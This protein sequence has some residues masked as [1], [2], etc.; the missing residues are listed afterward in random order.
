MKR[1]GMRRVN[2]KRLALLL[3]CVAAAVFAAC[4]RAVDEPADGHP[5]VRVAALHG[6][7]ALGLL[8]LMDTHDRG[9]AVL[10]YT[11]EILGAPMEV[12]P[13][14]VRGDVDIAVVPGNLAAV[15]YNQMD[16]AIQ[17]LAVVT[18][19]VLH[20]VDATDEV[21]SVEDLRGRT[22]FATGE[23]ATP[24]F[25]L[26]YV[27]VQNGLIPGADVFIEFRSQPPEIA[28]A[29]ELGHAEVALLPEPFVSNITA[30]FDHLRVALDWTEEWNRAQSNYGLMMSV[31]VAR[32]D[33]IENHPETVA[34][35]MEAYAQSIA[36]MTTELDAA[37]QLAVDFGLIG[38]ANIAR[39]AIPRTHM[40]F[41]TGEEKQRNLN[42]LFRVLY[43]ANPQSVGGRLP[44]DAFFFIP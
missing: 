29:F 20:I 32:R 28:A 14:L 18:L 26:N 21:H 13:L 10:E 8:H 34:A 42:G 6:P 9:L 19:G 4:G 22:I 7:T 39:T 2:I 35:F 17:G 24:E 12:P 36:F 44:D 23:G 16:G 3:M 41:I 27:L 5:T 11:F 31:V 43:D 33:F 1:L 38:N 30:Q 25:A 15:L 37:A 40:V